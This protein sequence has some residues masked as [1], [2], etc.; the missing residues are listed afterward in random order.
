MHE[1]F[2]L[3]RFSNIYHLLHDVVGELIL[4]HG[5]QSAVGPTSVSNTS[6]LNNTR[7]STRTPQ[8][9]KA[10]AQGLTWHS[11]LQSDVSLRL[12]RNTGVFGLGGGEEGTWLHRYENEVFWRW[13][14]R[15]V[16]LF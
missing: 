10:D 9:Q 5:V 6:N 12:N 1:Q 3:C 2:A 13:Q 16:L 8:A 4:H 14:F 15:L 11:Y 7:V